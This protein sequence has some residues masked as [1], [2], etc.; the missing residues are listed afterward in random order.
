MKL[1]NRNTCQGGTLVITIVISALVGLMLAAYLSMVSAQLTFT[2]R[3]QIWNNCIP[4]CEAG[5]EEALAHLNHPSTTTDFAINNWREEHGLYH[6]NTELNGGKCM[7]RIDKSYPPII[8]VVG[9]MAGPL[10]QGFISRVVRVRTRLNQRFPTTILARGGIDMGGGARVDSFNSTNR[11]ESTPEGRYDPEKATDRALVATISRN[12]GAMN[13]GNA[14]IYGSIA[15]GPGGTPSIGPNGKVGSEEHNNL[16][17]G[18]IED[19]HYSDDAN[20][21]IPAGELPKPFGQ[22]LATPD[23][24]NRDYAYVFG[25]TGGTN[26]YRLRSI[27]LRNSS[28]ILI[29]GKA[30]IYVED[31]T[32]VSGQAQIVIASGASLELYAGGAVN[33]TGGGVLNN[34]FAKDFSLVGLDTCTRIKYTGGSAFTGTI[35]APNADITMGGNSDAYGAFVGKTFHIMGAVNVHY[36][37]ALGDVPNRGKFLADSWEETKFDPTWEEL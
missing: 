37:E 31:D 1:Q 34:G 13:L 7:M 36:D 14:D 35:Y 28:K 15:T 5:V 8:T 24:T 30:R 33:L 21:H 19:G 29:N 10:G 17:R 2:Q 11:A 22:P 26:D 16:N 3:S 23:T 4:L 6:K 9:S 32:E 27:S 18:G 20:M 25:R 12:P